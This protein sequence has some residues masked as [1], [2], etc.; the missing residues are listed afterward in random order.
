MLVNMAL[1]RCLCGVREEPVMLWLKLLLGYCLLVAF[2]LWF[3][4]R[5]R[6]VLPPQDSGLTSTQDDAVVPSRHN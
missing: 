1:T 5:S 4:H 3:G 2:G 6:S